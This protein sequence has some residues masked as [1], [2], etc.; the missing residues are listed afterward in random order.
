MA[1]YQESNKV[2]SVNNI[3]LIISTYS[4]GNK[5]TEELKYWPKIVA[6]S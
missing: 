4:Y 6:L 3:L 2:M 1:V 5:I